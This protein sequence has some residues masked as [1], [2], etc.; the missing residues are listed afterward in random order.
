M[1][2]VEHE[3]FESKEEAIRRETDIVSDNL[4]VE[5]FE[6]RVYVEDTDNGKRLKEEIEDLKELL[7]AYRNGE[8][9]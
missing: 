3:Q 7:A 6:K 4:K 9:E 1:W 8:L 5:D 2:I